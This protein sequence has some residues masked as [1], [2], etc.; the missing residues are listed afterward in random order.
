MNA[1]MGHLVVLDDSEAQ[2]ALTHYSLQLW[3]SLASE[4]PTECDYRQCGTLWVA[5]NED[6]LR[7]AR[8]KADYYN[9]HGVLAEFL[10]EKQLAECEPNLRHGLPGG[11]FVSIDAAV[12]PPAAARFL[13]EQACRQGAKIITGR[14]LKSLDDT[15]GYA[16]NATGT[17]AASLTPALPIRSRKGH[18][19][20]L[21]APEDFARHQVVELGYVKSTHSSEADSVVFNARQ[22]KNGELLLGS[23]RQYLAQNQA[24]NPRV[25]PEIVHRLLT[26]ATDYMPALA[27]APQ[28][29]SWTGFRAGTPDG[30]PLIGLCPGFERVYAATGHEGLGATTS[31][32]TARLLA[33]EI[34]KRSPAIDPHP[35]LPSR[36]N[37]PRFPGKE[38]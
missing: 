29:R 14:R 21:D 13:L 33:D 38:I 3:H 10:D 8:R 6:D 34:L 9:A 26:R 11:V 17:A 1:G 25:E 27:S 30:L 19:L 16:I 5:A 36:F 32:A 23:S 28:I 12:H 35:Y 20:V 18:I 24:E 15:G 31:L 22:N 4:L 7:L 37:A 2:F